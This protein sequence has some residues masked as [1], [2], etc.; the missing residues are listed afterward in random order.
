MQSAAGPEAGA[1]AL[2]R[3]SCSRYRFISIILDLFEGVYLLE[4]AMTDTSHLLS[5]HCRSPAQGTVVLAHEAMLSRNLVLLVALA[6]A[7]TAVA[8]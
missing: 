5:S 4:P 6:S 8:W 7:A 1:D 2:Q 3:H